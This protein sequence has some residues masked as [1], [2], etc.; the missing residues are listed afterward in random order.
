MTDIP[1][2]LLRDGQIAE[3]NQWRLDRG[4]ESKPHIADR[5]FSKLR[6]RNAEFTNCTFV[7]CNFKDADLMFANLRG[8]AFLYCNMY[9]TDLTNTILYDM[10]F[11][12]CTLNG[13]VF[14]NSIVAGSR[15]HDC[16]L[17]NTNWMCANTNETLFHHNRGL[18]DLGVTIR[19]WRMIVVQ[20][21]AGPRI[22]SGCRRFTIEGAR[23]WWGRPKFRAIGHSFEMLARV[24]LADTL[25]K[26]WKVTDE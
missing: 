26:D 8:A 10:N 13:A 11:T 12:D 2:D 6:L 24:D 14:S 5:D 19:G 1:I 18:I 17:R 20:T 16:D 23:D 22:C 7:R 9:L 15:F 3:W 25:T 21:D 4:P